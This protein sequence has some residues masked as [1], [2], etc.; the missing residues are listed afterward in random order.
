MPD[1][2]WLSCKTT[3]KNFKYSGYSNHLINTFV[4]SILSLHSLLWQLLQLEWHQNNSYL[5]VEIP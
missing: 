4:A 5:F 2:C 3:L 1:K